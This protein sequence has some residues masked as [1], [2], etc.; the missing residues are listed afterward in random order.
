MSLNTTS[1]L[2]HYI[3]RFQCYFRSVLLFSPGNLF[4]FVLFCFSLVGWLW[5]I[6]ICNLFWIFLR[7]KKKRRSMSFR[8]AQCHSLIYQVFLIWQHTFVFPTQILCCSLKVQLLGIV[9][10]VFFME[11]IAKLKIFEGCSTFLFFFFLCSLSY[12]ILLMVVSEVFW[13]NLKYFLCLKRDA[14]S[15]YCKHMKCSSGSPDQL[16]PLLF[17]LSAAYIPTLILHVGLIPPTWF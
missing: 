3:H 9:A 12:L 7:K 15:I 17:T 6:F 8:G 11:Y 14:D 2:V 16:Q 1:K 10:P 5:A 13:S 4:F